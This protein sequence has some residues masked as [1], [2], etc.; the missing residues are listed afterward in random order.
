MLENIFTGIV[1]SVTSGIILTAIV[2]RFP[3][4]WRVRIDKFSRKLK[5][6]APKGRT[7]YKHQLKNGGL[8][9]ADIGKW[10]VWSFGEDEV[11]PDPVYPDSFTAGAQVKAKAK[12]SHRSISQGTLTRFRFSAQFHSEDPD[13]TYFFFTTDDPVNLVANE[14]SIHLI[15]DKPSIAIKFGDEK[16]RNFPVTIYPQSP[17]GWRLHDEDARFIESALRRHSHMLARWSQD[18]DGQDRQVDT[19]TAEFDLEGWN[20][21]KAEIKR[22]FDEHAPGV[23]KD[24]D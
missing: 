22:R 5:R 7:V 11:E 9:F 8:K 23:W 16:T 13:K 1:S 19:V 24:L 10:Q 21:V 14:S 3:K 2:Y 20:D 17:N 12:N 15:D 6:E 4:F 18:I